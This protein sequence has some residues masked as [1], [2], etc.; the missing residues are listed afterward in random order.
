MLV[1]SFDQIVSLIRLTA[2]DSLRRQV[3][4][5]AGL[6]HLVRRK[7]HAADDPPLRDGRAQAAA[8]IEKGKVGRWRVIGR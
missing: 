4:D 8:G 3:F 1:R 6:D 5:N 7:D 2:G